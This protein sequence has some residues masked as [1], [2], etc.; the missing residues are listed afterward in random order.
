MGANGHQLAALA[1]AAATG[2]ACA[3]GSIEG[4]PGPPAGLRA[5]WTDRG[6]DLAWTDPE[7]ET[8]ASTAIVR[9]PAEAPPGGVDLEAPL[10][11]ARR[12]GGEGIVVY[13]GTGARFVDAG[14]DR[15]QGYVYRAYATD[16]SGRLGAPSND[17]STAAKEGVAPWGEPP[18]NVSAEAIGEGVRISW[19]NPA[20]PTDHL[21]LVRGVGEA[22]LGPTD[23]HLLIAD[24]STRS[25]VDAWSGLAAEATYH[26]AL[27]AC[28]RCGACEGEGARV[29][30][31]TSASL[32]DPPSDLELELEGPVLHARWRPPAGGWDTMRLLVREGAPVEGPD[33][34]A[35]IRAHDGTEAEAAIPL[36]T[37]LPTTA[38]E[39]RRYHF[40]AFACQREACVEEGARADRSFTVLESLRGGGYVLFVPHAVADVCADRTDLGPA[41]TT[42]E[43]GWWASCER[44]CAV[45]TA[46]QLSEEGAAAA[47]ALGATLVTA[48]VPI[49][50]ALSS[51]FCRARETAAAVA[52]TAA[53]ETRPELTPFVHG[54]PRCDAV[55]WLG[56]G[57]ALGAAGANAVVVGH[58]GE[59]EE[60]LE[61]VDLAPLEVAV[62][63][64]EGDGPH[65]VARIPSEAWG[66]SP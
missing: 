20:A 58:E 43:P 64:P 38:V 1:L 12:V 53:V 62:V 46:Q 24:A 45:A 26:Y 4:P 32:E 47:D 11:P 29:S 41:R 65:L 56:A 9:W 50:R 27:F 14:A 40:A 55:R 7:G 57:A 21:R 6:V 54:E 30:F 23:G 61:L 8:F 49:D 25:Y 44:D 3:V 51:E 2:A 13:L 33:D 36:A 52:G 18:R 15:C 34:P 63:R 28:D 42:E 17:A 22:P 59:L 60:C 37:F 66:R 31:T 10:L 35:A 5:A 48:G 16:E 19:G 39:P